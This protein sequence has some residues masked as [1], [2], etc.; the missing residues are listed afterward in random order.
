[1]SSSKFIIAEFEDGLQVI[2]A[3]WYNADNSTSIWPAH[4]KTK[5]RINKAIMTREMPRD[6]SD[7]DVLAIKKVFGIASK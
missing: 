7:W 1:M 4:F 3:A 6:N 5:L 2:P